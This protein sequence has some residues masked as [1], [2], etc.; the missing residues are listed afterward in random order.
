MLFKT[1]QLKD[2]KNV[3]FIF[4]LCVSWSKGQTLEFSDGQRLNVQFALKLCIQEG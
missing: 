3:P 1:F 4:L 2:A